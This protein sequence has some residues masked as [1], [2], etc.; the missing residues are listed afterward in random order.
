MRRPSAFLCCA[1]LA[2]ALD[3]RGQAPHPT[4]SRG[5]VSYVAGD[6]QR[7]QIWVG[8]SVPTSGWRQTIAS[9]PSSQ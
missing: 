2:V 5:V 7:R 3:G 4:L 1:L 8:R 9:L 6:G